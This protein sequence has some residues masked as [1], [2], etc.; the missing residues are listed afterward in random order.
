MNETPALNNAVEGLVFSDHQP[1][2]TTIADRKELEASCIDLICKLEF[3][4]TKAGEMPRVD[5][6]DEASETGRAMLEM[7]AVFS[8]KSLTGEAADQANSE[9]DRG[10]VISY[11]FDEALKT[12]PMTNTILRTFWKAEEVEAVK[13]SHAKLGDALVR[14]CAATCLLYTSPSPRDLSTSRMPSSA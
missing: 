4:I 9:I 1:L 6:V 3:T 5:F 2:D 8:E 11:E 7:L 12:R 13:G 14:A 10:M